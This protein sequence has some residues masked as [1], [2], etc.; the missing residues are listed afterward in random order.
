M[1]IVVVEFADSVDITSL[2]VNGTVTVGAVAGGTVV[3]TG[4]VQNPTAAALTPHTHQVAAANG[5]VTVPAT[6]SGPAVAT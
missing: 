3:L 1:K 4:A 2:A 5:T 6:N